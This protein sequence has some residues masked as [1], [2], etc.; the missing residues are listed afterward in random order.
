MARAATWHPIGQTTWV[1]AAQGADGSNYY[2]DANSV[3]RLSPKVVEAWVKY[4]YTQPQSNP[5]LLGHGDY[6]MAKSLWYFNCT[7]QTLATGTTTLYGA[8]QDQVG[9]LAGQS[10]SPIAPD[11]VA[12]ALFNVVCASGMR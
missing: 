6:V 11:T 7:E 9:A 10:Y 5:D 4:V 8:T 12:A 2:Y 3:Q 1:E